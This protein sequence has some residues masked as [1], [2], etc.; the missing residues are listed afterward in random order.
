[1]RSRTVE[2]QCESDSE[3]A[4]LVPGRSEACEADA[5]AFRRWEG[6]NGTNR[7]AGHTMIGTPSS[8]VKTMPACQHVPVS[9]Q[10]EMMELRAFESQHCRAPAHLTQRGWSLH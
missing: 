5:R 1:M 7:F 9:T 6:R 10:E 4:H 3:H 8:L 2:D